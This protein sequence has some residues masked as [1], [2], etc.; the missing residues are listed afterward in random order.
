MDEHRAAAA[1]QARPRI[2]IDLDDEVIKMIIA[3]K[4]VARLP[5]RDA[6][7]AIVMSAVAR[8]FAP[9]VQRSDAAKR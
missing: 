3:P 7:R 1:G 2:V 8:V 9:S 6:D 5:R 4:A